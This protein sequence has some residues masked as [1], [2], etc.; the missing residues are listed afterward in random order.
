MMLYLF[1]MSHL[2]FYVEESVEV[3]PITQL[4]YFSS[5]SVVIPQSFPAAFQNSQRFQNLVSPFGNV[6][7]IRRI[8]DLYAGQGEE[9]LLATFKLIDMDKLAWKCSMNRKIL[10]PFR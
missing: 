2:F 10:M 1:I 8:L 6:S 3:W 4:F 5:L 7:L 9:G